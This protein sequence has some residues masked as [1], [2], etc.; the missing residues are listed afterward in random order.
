[1][2]GNAA[3]LL[4]ALSDPAFYP[5]PVRRVELIQT[6]ISWVLLTG[7][8]AY[9]IKKPVNLGFL[10][11]TTLAARRHYC[12]E[13]LRLNRRLAP[14]IYLDVVPIT[15]TAQ[16]P[17][18]AGDGPAIEYAV[19]MTEFAQSALLDNALPRGEAGPATIEQLARKI[20]DF[21][22]QLAPQD[23]APGHD[24]NATVLA[25]ARENFEQMLPLLDAPADIATLTAI[26][27]WTLREYGARTA[28]FQHRYAEGCV[29]EC[30]GDLHLGNIVLLD[31]AA[32]PFDCIEFNAAL[33]WMD[34]MNEVAFLM[35]DLEA[36]G[37]RDL[38]FT[39][40]GTYLETS[41]DYAGVRLLPFYV[42]YRAVVRAKINLIR[43]AQPGITPA[44]RQRAMADY[45]RYITL[46]A[47]HTRRPRGAVVITHGLS[48]SG[49][50]TLT[51]Q[52]L[53]TLGA[54]RIRSDVERKRLHGLNAL[55]QT[56]AATGTGIYAG[57]ATARTY[58][59]L[60]RHARSIAGAGL[61]VI[62][63]ATF[64]KHAQRAAFHALAVELGVPFA[65]V[66]VTATPAA[67]RARVSARAARGGDASEATLKVLE[68]QIENCEAL[69]V[70]EM[71][72][73]VLATSGTAAAERALCDELAQR[74][75]QPVPVQV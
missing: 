47:A 5:H 12:E 49:K 56:G 31:G 41:G 4:A 18:I 10:D 61:P 15:G 73:A 9:K 54:V 33:R 23:S 19:K 71:R 6:H 75:R 14:D 66:N 35:M 70:G 2:D 68:A 50:T 74:L 43:A 22:A 13:E 42:V 7:S 29:R 59:R 27:D 37:R 11:F 57:K 20:A 44:Q 1:V 69:T 53:A 24:A 58:D 26:R 65:I 8:Y 30:H 62:V 64:L 51:R 39:F 72:H 46:A 32:I 48:G 21:H 34:V 40:V 60:L 25:P 45:Q 17:A 3:P 28:Q 67:L 36:H 52:L 16:R 38:A 63:D 55:A